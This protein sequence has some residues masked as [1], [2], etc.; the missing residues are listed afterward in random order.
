MKSFLVVLTLIFAVAI[1][2]QGLCSRAYVSNSSV[3]LK[4]Y[5][6]GNFIVYTGHTTV[7]VTSESS[8]GGYITCAYGNGC[9]MG[10]VVFF[11]KNGKE[12]ASM[13]AYPGKAAY[14]Y[15]SDTIDAALAAWVNQFGT[16]SSVNSGDHQI[17]SPS[18]PMDSFRVCIGTYPVGANVT[19][20]STSIASTCQTPPS[21]PVSCTSLPDMNF[22]HGSIVTGNNL[23]SRKDVSAILQCSGGATSVTFSLSAPVT[24]DNGIINHFYV[25]NEILD[26]TPVTVNVSGSSTPLTFSSVIESATT[27]GTFTGSAVLI[28]AVN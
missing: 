28:M 24:L 10:P 19:T 20:S 16:S 7:T 27:G 17:L 5:E 26:S 9:W 4:S 18:I 14:V 8:S 25:N 1:P 3:E 6:P 13:V 15:S 21:P 22:A 12:V 23:Q 11:Y 2:G